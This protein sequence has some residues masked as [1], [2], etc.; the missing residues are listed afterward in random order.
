MKSVKLWKEI[1]RNIFDIEQL[2]F[3]KL[4]FA[5]G[6]EN[7]F[8]THHNWVYLLLGDYAQGDAFFI[9]IFFIHF[10]YRRYTIL[11]TYTN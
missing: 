5:G 7:F 1:S 4:S 8:E 3:K 6:I 11:V 2:V 9:F 10:I